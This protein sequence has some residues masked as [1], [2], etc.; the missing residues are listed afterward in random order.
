MQIVLREWD[1]APR[2]T[3]RPPKSLL[4]G[5]AKKAPAKAPLAAANAGKGKTIEET[6]QK[7]S[8]V[9]R[10]LA[11]AAAAQAPPAAPPPPLPACTV[12]HSLAQ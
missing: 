7:L 4:Q 8:Q 1:R 9:R 3:P 10:V 2:D 6:Y 12:Q 11:A 5:A